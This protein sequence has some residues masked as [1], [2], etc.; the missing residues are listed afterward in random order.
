MKKKLAVIVTVLLCNLTFSTTVLGEVDENKDTSNKNTAINE[1][2]E[3]STGKPTDK[4][5]DDKVS[6]PPKEEIPQQEKP[7][8]EEPKQQEET[9]KVEPKPKETTPPKEEEKQ[10][11][12][13]KPKEEKTTTENRK[14]QTPQTTNE[15]E[16]TTTIEPVIVPQQEN[17]VIEDIK[18]DVVEEIILSFNAN[19]E[20]YKKLDDFILHNVLTILLHNHP[21]ESALA[22]FSEDPFNDLVRR[23]SNEQIDELLMIIKDNPYE[24]DLD[25]EKIISRLQELKS[26]QEE[27]VTRLEA[28]AEEVKIE[29]EQFIQSE[30]VE[31]NGDEDEVEQQKGLLSLIGSTI[32]NIFKWFG[33]LF[34]LLISIF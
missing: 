24:N 17:E 21:H 1:N 25:F 33:T 22:A 8:E 19:N 30:T 28:E 4:Q 11:Q 9:P 18:K 27:Y 31:V 14:P 15:N 34:K 16:P 7:K 26:L 5:E 29:L 12:P 20:Y 32:S 10:T 23:L 2:D 3:T 6:E 13:N